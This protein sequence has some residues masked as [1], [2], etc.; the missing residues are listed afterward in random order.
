[1]RNAFTKPHAGSCCLLLPIWAPESQR[2]GSPL[3]ISVLLQ[4]AAHQQLSFQHLQQP[5]DRLGVMLV[6]SH[7]AP[8]AMGGACARP[9][10]LP[11]SQ[12]A[13]VGAGWPP[14]TLPH[15]TATAFTAGALP[16]HSTVCQRQI[17]HLNCKTP[18]PRLPPL[19]DSPGCSVSLTLLLNINR[20]KCL[21]ARCI[22]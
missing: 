22:K 8:A 11:G 16:A 3:L 18:Q 19:W 7:S 20:F 10:V 15:L 17:Q 2:L 13:A 5:E 12:R 1:M 4:P 9:S 6:S 14:A 21:K